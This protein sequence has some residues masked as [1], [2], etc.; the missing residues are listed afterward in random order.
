MAAGLAGASF[1]RSGRCWCGSHHLPPQRADLVGLTLDA[2]AAK[3]QSASLLDHRTSASVDGC[4]KLQQHRLEIVQDLLWAAVC[5]GTSAAPKHDWPSRRP[6]VALCRGTLQLHPVG[7]PCSGTGAQAP[8]S[9]LPAAAA[10]RLQTMR[11]QALYLKYEH[12]KPQ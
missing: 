9:R 5:G 3:Q 10:K 11:T 4:V 1:W 6:A 2:A 8:C 7:A 12:Q